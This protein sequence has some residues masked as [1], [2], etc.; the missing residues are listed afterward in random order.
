VFGRLYF[1]AV[2][3]P[4]ANVNSSDPGFT[5]SK[6]THPSTGDCNPPRML[7]LSPSDVHDLLLNVMARRPTGE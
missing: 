4:P 3:A 1:G 2:A 5:A 7:N 6:T